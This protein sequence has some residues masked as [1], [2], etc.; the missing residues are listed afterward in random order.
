MVALMTAPV[1]APAAND[2]VGATKDRPSSVLLVLGDSISAGYGLE[3]QQG[4]VSLLQ[5]RLAEQGSVF[6]VIN[7]SISGETTSGGLSRLPALL[8]RY[9]PE[10]LLLELGAND[11]LRGTPLTLIETNLIR[12]IR[13]AQQ[14]GARVLLLGMRIPSNYGSRYSEGFFQLF[15]SAADTTGSVYLPFLLEGVG[16]V[17]ELMQ[18]DGLHPNLLAQPRLLENSWP[19][20]A[21]LLDVRAAA[22]R[23]YLEEALKASYRGPHT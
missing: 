22:Q 4:W 16:G 17:P 23:S 6:E 15:R 8:Q 2:V 19:L 1:A 13:Q 12:L 21:P 7:A 20:L 10:I 11:G 18:S 5:Q 9:H 14:A 3:P